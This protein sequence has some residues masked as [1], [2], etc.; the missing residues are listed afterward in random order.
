MIQH[1]NKKIRQK[2]RFQINPWIHGTKW[3]TTA[4]HLP[5]FLIRSSIG[6]FSIPDTFIFSSLSFPY[7]RRFSSHLHI[8]LLVFRFRFICYFSFTCLDLFFLSV[9]CFFRLQSSVFC[10]LFLIFF[11][12]F[13]FVFISYILDLNLFIVIFY[14]RYICYF[15]LL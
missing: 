8:R 9:I 12:Y 1:I 13:L 14:L 4:L 11:C 3:L 7:S 5:P 2:I 10:S 6:F 15:F